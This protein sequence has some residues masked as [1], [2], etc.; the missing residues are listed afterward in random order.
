M[1]RK[2]FIY[3]SVVST[4]SIG[5][6]SLNCHNRNETLNKSLSQPKFLSHICDAKT[7]REIGT[8]YKKQFSSESRKDQLTDLILTDSSG[9][10][11]SQ[12]SDLSFIGSLVDQKIKQ[13][14]ETG[15]TVV[16][17]GWVLSVTEARQCALFSLA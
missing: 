6:P 10:P 16:V 5:M 11:P 17:K 13:D 4:V 7:L 2:T 14:F 12:T 3:L 1:K 8:A 9:T 15:Q